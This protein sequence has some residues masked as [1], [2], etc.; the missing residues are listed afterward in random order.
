MRGFGPDAVPVVGQQ[1]LNPCS[2]FFFFFFFC[3]GIQLYV[4]LSPYLYLF[5]LLFTGAKL[6]H[7]DFR[8]FADPSRIFTYNCAETFKTMSR[9]LSENMPGHA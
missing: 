2:I 6:R 9:N 3:F 4:L 5:N 1:G 8:I 7:N